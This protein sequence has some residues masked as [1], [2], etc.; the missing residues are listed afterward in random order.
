MVVAVSGT[1]SA[2]CLWLT[3]RRCDL[4]VAPRFAYRDF[5][6]LAPYRLLEGCARHVDRKLMCSARALDRL[7][8]SFD[9][10]PEASSVFDDC[11]LGEQPPERLLAVVEGQPADALARCSDQHPPERTVEV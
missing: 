3:D 7:E 9:Q 4:G 5:P 8:C 6:K 11:G 2:H 1:D 10:L